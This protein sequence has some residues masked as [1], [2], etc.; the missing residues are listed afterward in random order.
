MQTNVYTYVSLTMGARHSTPKV[1]LHGGPGWFLFDPEVF[2]YP[3][4]QML[5]GKMSVGIW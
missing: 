4:T 3:R 2:P 5:H 1:E